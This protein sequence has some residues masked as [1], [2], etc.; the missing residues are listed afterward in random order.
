M[1]KVIFSLPYTEDGIVVSSD[2]VTSFYTHAHMYHEML[3][4]EPFPGYVTINNERIPIDTP[5]IILVTAS[6]FHST[7]LEPQQHSLSSGMIAD[8]PVTAGYIK[9]AFRDEAF[10]RCFEQQ[11]S[12]PII[13]RNYTTNTLLTELLRKLAAQNYNIEK[14]RILLD[15]ILL[16]FTEKGKKLGSSPKKGTE[17]IVLNAVH[18]INEHFYESIALQ[19]VA[20]TLNISSQY[21]SA[22]FS[23]YM[24]ISFTEYLCNKRLRY[25]AYLLSEHKYN[26]TEVCYHCGYRNLSHFLR[27]FQK[28]YGITPKAYAKSSSSPFL[29][30]VK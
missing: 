8:T 7:T 24:G 27:S 16:E 23:K 1:E 9:V 6:D 14:R 12:Q 30:R 26:V 29:E 21:L 15:A 10:S 13:L 17:L 22:I 11:L 5:T 18:F 3:A 20:D 19:S 2:Y 4:Y 28:K 25:A